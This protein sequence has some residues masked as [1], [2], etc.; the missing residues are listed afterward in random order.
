MDRL[1]FTQDGVFTIWRANPFCYITVLGHS[2]KGLSSLLP[3]ETETYHRGPRLQQDLRRFQ[4]T[5]YFR[6]VQCVTLVTL[7]TGEFSITAEGL[8]LESTKRV[9]MEQF[10]LVGFVAIPPTGEFK[11]I[12]QRDISVLLD[13]LWRTCDEVSQRMHLP[14]ENLYGAIRY[15]HFLEHSRI[16]QG[17]EAMRVASGK[18]GLPFR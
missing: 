18:Y 2:T 4:E 13:G 9:L 17:E 1:S 3:E 7:P 11:R 6:P 12:M 8:D 16:I 10:P 14:L 15:S 5:H